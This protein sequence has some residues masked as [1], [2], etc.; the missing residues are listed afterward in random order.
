MDTSLRVVGPD[1]GAVFILNATRKQM[2][3]NHT[4]FAKLLGIS[5]ST[6]CAWRAAPASC[7]RIVVIE[8]PYSAGDPFGDPA[9]WTESDD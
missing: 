3:L 1:E 2:R 7:P 9:D 6:W 4:A 8:M 5:Y